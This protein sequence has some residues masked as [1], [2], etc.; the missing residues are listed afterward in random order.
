MRPRSINQRRTRSLTTS[1]L[2]G[3]ATSSV[4][5]FSAQPSA[6]AFEGS[7]AEDVIAKA[8]DAT[9]IRPLSVVR[10][11]IGA[12]LLVPAGIFASPSG[13]EGLQTAY[14]VLVVGPREYAFDRKLGDF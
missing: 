13:L 8:V 11:A 12:A 3:L 1:L 9:I 7:K 14:D 4:L 2:I 6:A 10:L 5:L